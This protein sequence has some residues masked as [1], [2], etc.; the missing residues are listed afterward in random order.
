[1]EYAVKFV[2]IGKEPIGLMRHF[3]EQGYVKAY[4]RFCDLANPQIE[5]WNEEY[6][7]LGL[8]DTSTSVDENNH[9]VVD[10]PYIKFMREKNYN[11]ARTIQ[12]FP[13]KKF[14]VGSEINFEGVLRDGTIM[15]VVLVPRE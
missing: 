14:Q 6:D 11:I 4:Q 5:K 13:F 12:E 1:M 15:Y 7:T 9:V 2:Y 3:I 10:H 8:E